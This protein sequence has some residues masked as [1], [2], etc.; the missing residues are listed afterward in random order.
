MPVVVSGVV[1]LKKALKMYA[2]DLKREM[3]T[4][5]RQAMKEVTDAAKAKVPGSAPGGLYNWQDNGNEAKGMLRAGGFPKYNSAVIRKGLTY[6]LGTSRINPKGFQALYSMFNASPVGAIVETAG[7]VHPF[8]RRQKAARKYGE[9]SKNIGQSNNPDAGRRFTLAMN[10]VGPLKQYDK[11][12]RGRGRLL[13][14]AYAENQGKALD[15]TMKAI[16]KATVEFDKRATLHNTR[17]VSY[18]AV[19]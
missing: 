8:G 2:P 17:A 13:Y 3:D 10:G 9:S 5:I 12:D 16:Q 7:R 19:A 15:A 1:E 11:F 6:S 18:G 4:T 14:A